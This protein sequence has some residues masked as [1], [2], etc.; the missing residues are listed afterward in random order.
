MVEERNI[1][2]IFF[3]LFDKD[4]VKVVNVGVDEDISSEGD[5]FSDQVFSFDFLIVN[6]QQYLIRLL[7]R[8]FFFVKLINICEG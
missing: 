7:I 6:V 2:R 1:I 8:F 5:K 4:K 3:V